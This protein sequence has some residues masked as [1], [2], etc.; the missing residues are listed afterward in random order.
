MNRI[1]RFVIWICSKFN[2]DEV[3]QIIYGLQEVLADRNP[4]VKPKDDFKEKHP[5]YR[6]FYVDPLPPLTKQPSKQADSPRLEWL[7][8][9]KDYEHKHGKPLKPV[10][11]HKQLSVP[12][13]CQ[14]EHCRAPA[15]YLYYND[16]KRRSQLR[17]KVQ[18]HKRHHPTKKAKYFCPHCHK[19]LYR[20]KNQKLVTI[21]KCGN[22]RCPAFIKAKNKLNNSEKQQQKIKLSQ[23][24]LR[25]QYREYHFK[26]SKLKHS[27]PDNPKIDLS[28]IHN[29]SNILG[30]VFLSYYQAGVF[31][32]SNYS[33]K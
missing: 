10:K 31:K 20:W 28:R 27:T 19:A 29:S 30:L 33:H 18:T 3:I 23:F 15:Q 8:L 32:D 1:A 25:Y 11:R 14:C 16:G 4:E 21:F 22:D 2:R 26:P 13:Q 5:N 7:Q 6:D 24:K 12:N 9:L 17:C